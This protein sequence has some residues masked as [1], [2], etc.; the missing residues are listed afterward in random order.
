MQ[1]NV[2]AMVGFSVSYKFISSFN[3][4]SRGTVTRLHDKRLPGKPD[5]VLPKYRTI[6]FVH[7]CFWH[8]HS[9]CKYFVVPKTRTSWWTKK[10][11]RNQELDGKNIKAL[12]LDSWRVLT[13]FECQLKSNK[14]EVTFR[15]L[16]KSIKA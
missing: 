11:N 9:K 15:N 4:W 13:I 6:I 8:G 7:G 10:I 2:C 3:V 5:I 14:V 1:Q 12:R 16:L